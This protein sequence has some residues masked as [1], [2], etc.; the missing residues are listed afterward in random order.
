[1]LFSLWALVEIPLPWCLR[2]TSDGSDRSALLIP[3][4]SRIHSKQR[5]ERWILKMRTVVSLAMRL[6]TSSESGFVIAKKAVKVCNARA[7]VATGQEKEW[8]R[9]R[10]VLLPYRDVQKMQ[11]SPQA[12]EEWIVSGA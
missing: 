3:R 1:M 7:S 9:V 12:V 6:N 11:Q 2:G 10:C 4:I 8:R 5:P